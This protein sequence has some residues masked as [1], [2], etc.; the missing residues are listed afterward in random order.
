MLRDVPKVGVRA[1]QGR[2]TID[3]DLSDHAVD[4]TSNGDSL[5]TERAK[6]AGG[7]DMALEIWL[8]TRE[9]S[10]CG[11]RLVESSRASKSLEHL[12]NYDW[13]HG[14]VFLIREGL[15]EPFYVRRFGSVEKVHPGI[16][17]DDDHE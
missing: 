12:R 6:Q 7:S 9:C 1:Q 14:D 4:G 15:V 3:A 13:K 8:D 11:V 5:R 17:V 10:Q 2:V 16:R